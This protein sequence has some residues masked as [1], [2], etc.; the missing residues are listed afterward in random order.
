MPLSASFVFCSKLSY[1]SG[2]S[3]FADVLLTLIVLFAG[4]GEARYA[5]SVA[6]CC[7]KKREESIVFRRTRRTFGM[8]RWLVGGGGREEYT[9]VFTLPPLRHDA[10]A[11]CSMVG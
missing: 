6:V 10:L 4:A 3:V 11:I 8:N 9:N 1:T 2:V 7:C 5:D